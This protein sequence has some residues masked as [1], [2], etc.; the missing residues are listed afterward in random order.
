MQ[1]TFILDICRCEEF[2][3]WFLSSVSKDNVLTDAELEA[4]AAIPEEAR[5]S[6]KILD[7]AL[8]TIGDTD[9]TGA[10]MTDAELEKQVNIR[11]QL[12]L[13]MIYLSGW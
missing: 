7:E 6:G 10:N 3:D 5:L 12:I 4:Y 9:L 13:W 1:V 2:M 11:R 8:A